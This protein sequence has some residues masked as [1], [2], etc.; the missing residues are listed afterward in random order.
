MANYKLEEMN[1][2]RNTGK[3]TVYPKVVTNRTMDTNDI[4]EKMK[5]YNLGIAPSTTKAVLENISNI[6]VTMLSMGY[7]VKL[8]G[9]GIFSLTIG[10][11]DN[12]PKELEDDADKMP[13]RKV[14]VKGMN[15]KMAPN[16]LKRLKSETDL[17]RCESEV[18]QLVKSP[19]TEKERI[20]RALDVIKHHGFIKLQ[21]YA[22]INELKRTAASEDLRRITAR[23]NP[24]LMSVGS[25]T[26]KAWIATPHP[27]AEIDR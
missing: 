22:N 17:E 26:H 23:E 16:L 2:L 12:K 18:T 3:R 5:G 24:P 8:D 11:E 27:S 13:Y 20:H 10:F 15:F 4:V 6:L 14:G 19:Y 7:N 1:D 21:T 25:G 9:I